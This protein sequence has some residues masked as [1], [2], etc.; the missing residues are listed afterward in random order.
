[1]ASLQDALLAQPMD[2]EDLAKVGRRQKACPYY[3]ARSA[4][5]EAHL[6]L[7]PYSALLAQVGSLLPLTDA[8][9]ISQHGSQLPAD[10]KADLMLHYCTLQA[11]GGNVLLPSH[12]MIPS[13]G[14]EKLWLR[15]ITQ[16]PTPKSWMV[17]L[18][19]STLLAHF[20]FCSP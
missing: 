15:P 5:P 16:S 4:I 9:A 12:K 19:C 10:P 1:M 14:F 7:L 2:V 3:T 13:T 6:V 18:L 17:L 20:S 11:R 8:F